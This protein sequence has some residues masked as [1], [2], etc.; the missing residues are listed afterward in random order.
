MSLS[1]QPPQRG[2]YGRGG[3]NRPPMER[4]LKPSE[5]RV[6]ILTLPEIPGLDDKQ[7]EKLTKT[8]SKE[9]KDINKINEERENIRIQI[10]N[11]S[12]KANAKANGEKLLVKLDE[13]VEKTRIKYD[14]KYRSILTEEQYQ[15][16]TQHWK[17]IEFRKPPRQESF[18][19]APR[20]APAP[21]QERD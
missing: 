3:G 16:L 17:E 12:L 20:Q 9:Q 19:R 1:A 11:P 14:K 15:I 21:G 7:R 8:L 5:L 13:K 6:G 18:P 2:S 10:E 4:R